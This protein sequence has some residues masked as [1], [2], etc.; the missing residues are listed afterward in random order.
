MTHADRLV[1]CAETAIKTM[2]FAAN[3]TKNRDRRFALHDS[4][5]YLDMAVAAYRSAPPVDVEACARVLYDRI[6]ARS[7]LGW[8]NTVDYYR[9]EMRGHAL[10]VLRAE[11][12]DP[13]RPMDFLTR[14][15]ERLA[16]LG[17]RVS[18]LGPAPAAMARRAGRHRAQLVLQAESRGELQRALAAWMPALDALPEARRVRWALD[19]DPL[20][21]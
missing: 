12:A 14:A 10:A 18:A 11:A 6:Y 20:E 1:E 3:H 2:R 4:A 5:D 17:S 21:V 9:K 13:Q 19:V 7:L 16:T 8:D 15:G